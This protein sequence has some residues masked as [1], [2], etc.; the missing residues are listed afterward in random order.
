MPEE[1]ERIPGLLDKLAAIRQ[2]ASVAMGICASFQEAKNKSI[3]IIGFVTTPKVAKLLNGQVIQPDQ[4][5][6]TARML[7]NGQP[8]RALPITASLCLAVAARISGSIVHANTRET[9]NERLSIGMPSGM[10]EANAMVTQQDG[11]WYAKSVTLMR[12]QR[13]L[14]DGFVYARASALRSI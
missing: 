9:S 4:I 5:N 7:S 8:H 10:L 2:T 11:A 6:I 13:R 14:F 12:T 3:P 1:I